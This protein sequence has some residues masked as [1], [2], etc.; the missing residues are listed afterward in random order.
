MLPPPSSGDIYFD[1]EG[2]PLID[3]GLEYLFGVY[4]GA[5]SDARFDEFW[6]HQFFVGENPPTEAI[7]QL[8]LK[9]ALKDVKL[10]ITDVSCI[11]RRR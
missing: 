7:L 10:K 1:I 11:S 2:Y 4:S 6:A 9:K 8:Y 5:Q 3:G